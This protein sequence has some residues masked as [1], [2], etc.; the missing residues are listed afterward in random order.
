[1]SVPPCTL[2]TETKPQYAQTFVVNTTGLP[3]GLLTDWGAARVVQGDGAFARVLLLNE[4]SF[5]IITLA[6]A[7]KIDP[8]ARA[9]STGIAGL[10]GA[11][12]VTWVRPLTRRLQLLFGWGDVAGT[13][14]TE[15]LALPSTELRPACAWRQH[16][17]A[18]QPFFVQDYKRWSDEDKIA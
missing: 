13:P 6:R 15:E 18:P 14:T 3:A 16:P 2:C 17:T 1:M 4:D 12:K 11:P 7:A 5:L 10:P 8:A 9:I